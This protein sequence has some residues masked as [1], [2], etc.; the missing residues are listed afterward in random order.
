MIFKKKFC[1]NVKNHIGEHIKIH[2]KIRDEDIKV[3]TL[4][5]AGSTSVIGCWEE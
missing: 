2:I 3:F 1:V 4:A 5:I